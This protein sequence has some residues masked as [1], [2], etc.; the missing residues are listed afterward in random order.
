MADF[1]VRVADE[2]YPLGSHMVAFVL[3]RNKVLPK[4]HLAG[5]RGAATYYE[6][7]RALCACWYALVFS[8]PFE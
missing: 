8:L 7:K 6:A 4:R 2:G 1:A 5:Y 3:S